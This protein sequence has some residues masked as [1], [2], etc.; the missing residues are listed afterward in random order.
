MRRIL[1]LSAV[2][3]ATVIPLSAIATHPNQELV[4]P[5]LVLGGGW[6]GEITIMAQGAESSFGGIAFFDQSGLPLQLKVDGITTEH[7]GYDISSGSAKTFKLLRE[8]PVVVGYAIATQLVFEGA[9]R[10]SITGFLTCRY[11]P[12]GSVVLQ[13]CV[14][15]S[16][17]L[18][19]ARVPF[20][21]TGENR[22]GVAMLSLTRTP[23]TLR[24]F[25]QDGTFEDEETISFDSFSQTARFVDEVFPG[26][27][28]VRGFIE[29]SSEGSFEMLPLNQDGTNLSPAPLLTG[30]MEGTL[31]LRLLRTIEGTISLTREGD[32]LF[33]VAHLPSSHT[34]TLATGA[35]REGKLFLSL[36]SKH[37]ESD[38]AIETLLLATTVGPLEGA[39]GSAIVMDESGAVQE[40]G[41][42][43][44]QIK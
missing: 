17:S 32:C 29:A 25:S 5:H 15:S 22:T 33:G 43:E 38:Q 42:F 37:P 20:D 44:L 21:N 31:I 18:H 12:R 11:Q 6:H 26:A 27:R 30:A 36:H 9:G 3:G 13:V 40:R 19:L 23:I 39:S 34:P 16:P 41:T 4:F 1:W 8:G 24:R 35:L 10:G 28:S 7:V 2:L 14:S